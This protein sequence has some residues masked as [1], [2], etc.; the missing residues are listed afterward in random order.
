MRFRRRRLNAALARTCRKAMPVQ[1]IN[2]ACRSKAGA[3]RCGLPCLIRG[4]CCHLLQYQGNVFSTCTNR[5]VQ[6]SGYSV[7]SSC[8]ARGVGS[9][10]IGMSW[11]NSIMC[12]LSPNF[13][14]AVSSQVERRSSPKPNPACHIP[15]LAKAPCALTTRPSRLPGSCCAQ[16]TV[17]AGSGLTRR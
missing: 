11:A 13:V 1:R 2:L 4:C 8:L 12:Q 15:R 17:S 3:A 7:C 14:I 6:G 16:I 5:I 9:S 10:I